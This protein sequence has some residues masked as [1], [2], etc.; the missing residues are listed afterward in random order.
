MISIV[1]WQLYGGGGIIGAFCM[2]RE[3]TIIRD[4]LYSCNFN[5]HHAYHFSHQSSVCVCVCKLINIAC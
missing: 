3:K 5:L 4:R 2:K 1:Q